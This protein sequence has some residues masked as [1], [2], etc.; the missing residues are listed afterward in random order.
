MAGARADERGRGWRQRIRH[1]KNRPPRLAGVGSSRDFRAIGTGTT[2]ESAMCRLKYGKAALT[3]LT[4]SSSRPHLQKSQ[5]PSKP[6]S[7]LDLASH[8]I[9]ANSS[10]MST[11]VVS[12]P[13]KVLLAGGYLV[14]DQAYSGLVAGTS[15][16]FYSAVQSRKLPP[17]GQRAVTV[18]SPQFRAAAWKYDITDGE[19]A[20]IVQEAEGSTRYVCSNMMMH[21]AC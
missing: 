11:T 7:L 3:L 8:C 6:T 19:E 4:T 20:V 21:L 15:S 14:L 9:I 12:C 5:Y 17:G 10:T 13:G 1:T 18:R 16:R 2:F